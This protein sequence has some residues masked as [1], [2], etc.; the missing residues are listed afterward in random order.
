MYFSFPILPQC[1]LLPQK[2]C[3]ISSGH[4]SIAGR[5]KIPPIIRH[6]VKVVS[7][8][9]QLRPNCKIIW[10]LRVRWCSQCGKGKK[11]FWCRCEHNFYYLHLLNWYKLIYVILKLV[12]LVDQYEVSQLLLIISLAVAS[13]VSKHQLRQIQIN[14]PVQLHSQIQLHPAQNIV[15]QLV[16]QIRHYFCQRN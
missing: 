5:D 7:T 6:T 13:H 3:S 15:D 9:T 10:W 12:D 8:I 14:S 16:Q 2:C 4:V 1:F 11:S